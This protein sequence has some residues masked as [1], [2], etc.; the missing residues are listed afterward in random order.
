ML[1]LFHGL[2]G[3]SEGMDPRLK[4]HFQSLAH[5][6][7]PELLLV[8]CGD[9]RFEQVL[10]AQPGQVFVVRCVGNIIAPADQ[11]GHSVGDVSEA[12]A[13]EYGL[14]VLG[15]RDIA[16]CGHSNCGA[17][18]ALLRGRQQLHQ[19]AP[20]LA[21]WLAHAE[22][23]LERL[24]CSKLSFPAGLAEADR[25][26]QE[27][28]LLQLEHVSSF[29]P[30]KRRAAEVRLHALWFDIG[31]AMMHLYEAD[32]AR[33]VPLDEAEVLRLLTPGADVPPTTR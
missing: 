10:G 24:A 25:L 9:S 11:S 18:A 20:N 32:K 12:S 4:A 21:T 14:E 30:V 22:P 7:S 31:Q 33:F 6:Q 23:S 17:M 15:I 8:A 27:N 3:A 19:S 5:K 28:V 26:S 2:V 16:V 1:H 29:Q 13:I